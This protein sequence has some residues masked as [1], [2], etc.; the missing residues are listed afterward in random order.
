[1]SKFELEKEIKEKRICYGPC[2]KRGAKLCCCEFFI[3]L[4]QSPIMKRHVYRELECLV[5]LVEQM[6]G[7]GSNGIFI[8]KD[9]GWNTCDL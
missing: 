8:A 6:I 7:L 1:M 5:N 2:G 9:D 4:K 3:K